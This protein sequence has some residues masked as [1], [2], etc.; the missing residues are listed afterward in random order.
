MNNN[1]LAIDAVLKTQLCVLIKNLHFSETKYFLINIY[2][3][4]LRTISKWHPIQTQKEY[5]NK[6]K[7]LILKIALINLDFR[8]QKKLIYE[9]RLKMCNF[10][11]TYTAKIINITLA[12]VTSS[13]ANARVAVLVLRKHASYIQMEMV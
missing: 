7:L 13:R 11:Y 10:K 2:N 3:N 8:Q 5:E 12:M 4:K 9:S 1:L 6:I